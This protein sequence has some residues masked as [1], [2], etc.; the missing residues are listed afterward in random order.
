[1][2]ARDISDDWYR[3]LLSKAVKQD[4]DE[5]VNSEIKFITFNYDRSIEFYFYNSLKHRFNIPELEIIKYL[6]KIEFVHVHGK[7][8]YLPWETDNEEQT[9]D[10]ISARNIE[11]IRTASEFI[12]ILH[13][14]DEEEILNKVK[15]IV[16]SAKRIIFLGFGYHEFNLK[17]LHFQNWTTNEVFGTAFKK[18]K[19][20]VDKISDTTSNK[21]K[22]YNLF[23]KTI[24]QFFRENLPID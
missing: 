20:E 21:I 22:S 17:K 1:L 13:E 10:Y 2:Y 16:E 5:I 19:I 15:T 9:V 6:D 12:R 3:Y 23:D 4:L 8:G 14:D 11:S 7:L 18:T 24:V